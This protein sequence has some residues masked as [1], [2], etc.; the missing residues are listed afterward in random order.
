M[1]DKLSERQEKIYTFIRS[2][3]EAKQYPPTIREIGE[4]VKIIIDAEKLLKDDELAALA[5]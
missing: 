2:F 5:S 3:T 4:A 1:A